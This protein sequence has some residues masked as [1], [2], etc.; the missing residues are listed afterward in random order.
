MQK[1]D[2]IKLYI[3][4]IGVNGEGIGH[5]EGMAFFVPGAIKG[6]TITAGITKLKKKI[7]FA[8][9]ISIDEPSPDRVAPVCPIA[10]Q[11]GGCQIQEL[12]YEKQLEWKAAKVRSDL[13]RLGHFEENFVDSILK[14]IIGMDEPIRYRNKA[15]YPVGRAKD[16]SIVTGFYAN[17]SHRIVPIDDC[18]LGS[19]DNAI[20]TRTVTDFMQ[21]F[22]IEPYD[23]ATGSGLV[24]HILVRYG[25]KSGEIMVCLILNG[26][27][28]SGKIFP[29]GQKGASEDLEKLLVQ[30][31]VDNVPG[32]ASVCINTN[33][34]RDNVILGN[35]TRVIYGSKT[36]E[37]QIGDIKFSISAESFFQVN[38][39]QTEKLYNKALEYAALTGEE[40]VW[41]LYCGIG[42]ISLFLARDAKKVY[43]IEIVERAVED[44]KK[45]AELNGLTNTEFYAGK[46]E[47]VLPEFYRKAAAENSD[48]ASIHP[49][50]ICV[51]PPR[52]GLDEKCIET[53]L[54]MQPKRIVYVSCNPS[55]LARDLEMLVDGGYELVEVTPVD[56]FPNTVHVETVCLMSRV[57][58]K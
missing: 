32:I 7:G 54:Q 36:I 29:K 9:V 41:D 37:D 44:A 56:Q 6:D 3:E 23:E 50:V 25:Y 53:M 33:T 16:G 22:G 1:N 49:D 40:T 43:G 42:S 24:R 57:D 26:E 35:K 31:L 47:E 13:I 19:E 14:P 34:R 38:P 28:L 30:R 11:C 58:G 46:A 52:K 18:I 48:D 5:F 15:Q 4:D 27:S 8:R 21:E 55:T 39:F 10:K 12:S 45:N 51:D 2:V 20:I 17:H